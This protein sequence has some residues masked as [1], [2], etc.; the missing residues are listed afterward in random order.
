M[1]GSELQYHAMCLKIIAGCCFGKNAAT[2][3]K[4][5]GL[6][7]LNEVLDVIIGVDKQHPAARR[8]S[9][10]DALG[11]PGFA[12]G[13]DDDEAFEAAKRLV[14]SAHVEYLH[15]VYT[16]ASSQNIEASADSKNRIHG[17]SRIWPDD[18]EIPAGGSLSMSFDDDVDD[19]SEGRA[20]PETLVDAWLGSS[21]AASQDSDCLMSV[22]VDDIE[23]AIAAKDE[24]E[25][26]PS[27]MSPRQYVC[28]SVIPFLVAYF[29]KNH[30][31]NLGS[32]TPPREAIRTRMLDAATR[33][34]RAIAGHGPLGGRLWSVL[35]MLLISQLSM[36]DQE[37]VYET[38]LLEVDDEYLENIDNSVLM[39]N[40]EGESF[41]IAWKEFTSNFSMRNLG[42]KASAVFN[43]SM[44]VGVG[45]R[46]LVCMLMQD[47][48]VP[49]SDPQVSF[50]TIVQHL[51]GYLAAAQPTDDEEILCRFLRVLRGALYT[52]QGLGDD[53][54][55]ATI[56]ARHWQMF[57]A[58]ESVLQ[59]KTSRDHLR[60]VQNKYAQ[61]GVAV[62]AMRLLSHGNARVSA[63]SVK[64]LVALTDEGNSEVQQIIYDSM[65]DSASNDEQD[66]AAGR[67][68]DTMLRMSRDASPAAN[69]HPSKENSMSIDH[70]EFFRTIHG[71]FEK[72]T[73]EIKEY[74]AA[75]NLSTQR[76][77]SVSGSGGGLSPRMSDQVTLR[78]RRTSS[79]GG[80]NDQTKMSENFFSNLLESGRLM[81]M[82]RLVQLL[83]EGRFEKLQRLFQSQT[84]LGTESH[85]IL[86]D[87]VNLV[88]TLH[89]GVLMTF[90]DSM[91]GVSTVVP[92]L[93]EVTTQAWSTLLELIQGP[94]VGNATSLVRT[95][96]LSVAE[97][98][99]SACRYHDDADLKNTDM[100]NTNI[101]GLQCHLKGLILD[102]YLAL[103]E[104]TP[105][106]HHHDHAHINLS[107]GDADDSRPSSA[108]ESQH[109]ES[110]SLSRN[111]VLGRMIEVINYSSLIEEAE[112]VRC[113]CIAD[114]EATAKHY[115][116][117]KRF[118]LGQSLKGI[119]KGIAVQGDREEEEA[120]A[121]RDLERLNELRSEALKRLFLTV[122]LDQRDMNT[123][124]KGRDQCDAPFCMKCKRVGRYCFG[125]A[126]THTPELEHFYTENTCSVEVI[127]NN[128]IEKVNFELT[129]E[130]RHRNQDK[131]WQ[132]RALQTIYDVPRPNPKEKIEA[133][134]D[135]MVLLLYT[136]RRESQ[137]ANLLQSDDIS[138]RIG[139]LGIVAFFADEER[140]QNML[141]APFFVS[142]VGM[143]VLVMT[144][145]ESHAEW[146]QNFASVVV[147]RLL[148]WVQMVLCTMC[149]CLF[150]VKES[151]IISFE[152][153]QRAVDNSIQI[154][155]GDTLLLGGKKL[156]ADDDVDAGGNGGDDTA[157]ERSGGGGSVKM[158][159]GDGA[160]PSS[161]T[162]QNWVPVFRN[163]R[164]WFHMLFV[165]AAFAAGLGSPFFLSIHLLDFLL[166][167]S[168][169]QEVLQSARVGGPMLARTFLVGILVIVLYSVVSFVAFRDYLP[170]DDVSLLTDVCTGGGCLSGEEN[171]YKDRR[172]R[173]CSTLYECVGIHLV[174]GLMGSIG[175]VFGDPVNEWFPFKQ[176]P[177][178]V[179][180]ET[181][182]Q[183]RTVYIMSFLILWVFLL[184]N[185]MTAQ[186][187]EAFVQIRSQ[188]VEAQRDLEERC[189]ICSLDRFTFE[190]RRSTGASGF[191]HH[192]EHEH[193]PL[194]YLYYMDYLL[195]KDE[196]LYTGIE[197]YIARSLFGKRGK[198]CDWIPINRALQL[199]EDRAETARKEQA[200][201]PVM[202]VMAMTKLLESNLRAMSNLLETRLSNMEKF[203]GVHEDMGGVGSG[204]GV[205][206]GV[207]GVTS[208]AAAGGGDGH[209]AEDA[210]SVTTMYSEDVSDNDPL[211]PISRS[212]LLS[213]EP[214]EPTNEG[215]DVGERSGEQDDANSED[216]GDAMILPEGEGEG[217]G[218][219][220]DDVLPPVRTPTPQPTA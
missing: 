112:T 78:N 57:E 216:N 170:R 147:V 31:V 211:R 183:V 107:G 47:G 34:S 40:H 75:M 83:T 141:V 87:L 181:T 10:V 201:Q 2:E 202:K 32:L 165:G 197:T 187:V 184:S 200:N 16:E 148:S 89:P 74:H 114:W 6:L 152:A 168:A 42:I 136:M 73:S 196:T 68:I 80:L 178:G 214:E 115:R 213:V 22:L 119:V 150:L 146:E 45:E 109:G 63:E 186:I 90:S 128:R 179:G 43:P 12:S 15:T 121:L 81:E 54:H 220:D 70:A 84:N 218:G 176:V 125:H 135:R 139:L 159:S 69:A 37:A 215:G 108:T 151:T 38:K 164:V 142:L 28:G 194:Y 41:K 172:L 155:Q 124:Q 86:I 95:H 7:S 35:C 50:L 56:N 24:N 96:Y 137:L 156:R 113:K 72:A 129:E 190:S 97:R 98:Y 33:L 88:E 193:N 182:F 4:A 195:T 173:H 104:G 217:E 175:D 149:F 62:A 3:V 191:Q 177:R 133:M 76:R 123:V 27:D 140:Y 185:I 166:H 100:G 79:I 212:L 52:D 205:Q 163:H 5:S 203:L 29:K 199:E 157:V 219:A 171:P 53:A 25:R 64:L 210:E 19:I 99:M 105:S 8:M 120:D 49:N 134:I 59:T 103:I 92:L 61:A 180:D 65:T 106:A 101:V 1:D 208:A 11:G 154:L 91:D 145:G 189:F 161:T 18:E 153:R 130:C 77:S 188:K 26:H 174:Q 55:V 111:F 160:V 198:R 60:R 192:L 66:T 71:M 20:R 110:G 127:V 167:S 122:E 23:E 82:M 138:A 36:N 21:L 126:Y 17:A 14:R 207:Q 162:F 30:I 94:C 117:L 206:A 44:M 131:A 46:N 9:T 144:Y 204:G 169:G 39:S 102:T 48:Y 13:D 118:G 158:Q 93:V 143:L 209:G 51:A 85:D 116:A 132:A 58:E 67:N